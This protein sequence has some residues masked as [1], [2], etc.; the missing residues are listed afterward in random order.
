MQNYQN[1][2]ESATFKHAKTVKDS[3]SLLFKSINQSEDTPDGSI[4]DEDI[5]KFD[6]LE[7]GSQ[8]L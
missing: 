6:I 7:E 8:T 1:L 4:A 3:D 5:I 2:K